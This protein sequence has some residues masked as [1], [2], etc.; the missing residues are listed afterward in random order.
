MSDH[1]YVYEERAAHRRALALAEAEVERLTEKLHDQ[2]NVVCPHLPGHETHSPP[3]GA[4][5]SWFGVLIHREAELE[6]LREELRQTTMASDMDRADVERLR[7]VDA[8]RDR[9]YKSLQE[10]VARL[11]RIQEAALA[12]FRWD[13]DALVI[14]KQKRTG[15]PTKCREALRA[16]LEQP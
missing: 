16:A 10:D 4:I 7:G 15:T 12:Y 11:R 1:L 2:G 5:Q 13:A 3:C 14:E 6:R 9:E 8:T